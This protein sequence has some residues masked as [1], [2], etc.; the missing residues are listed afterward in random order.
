VLLH[1]LDHLDT[2]YVLISGAVAEIEEEIEPI[3]LDQLLD[4]CDRI[5]L[6]D[7]R[8]D[9][10]FGIR[11]ERARITRPIILGKGIG[12]E[13]LSGEQADAKTDVVTPMFVLWTC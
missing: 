7:Q 1:L 5:H 3:G 13:I 2:G 8:L 6:P 12:I 4:L 11:I 10:P 9:M